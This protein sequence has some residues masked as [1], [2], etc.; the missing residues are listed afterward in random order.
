[1]PRLFV[2]FTSLLSRCSPITS[3]NRLKQ[4][5]FNTAESPIR[6]QQ[7]LS[8]RRDFENKISP[9][10][11][12]LQ[13]S[14]NFSSSSR[15]ASASPNFSRNQPLEGKIPFQFTSLSIIFLQS[16]LLQQSSNSQ[17]S[18]SLYHPSRSIPVSLTPFQS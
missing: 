13:R 6:P 7:C 16:I 11:I 18:P 12:P 2:N 10:L 14:P 5:C 3:F 1:M 4:I 8:L 15:K 17:S 9:L